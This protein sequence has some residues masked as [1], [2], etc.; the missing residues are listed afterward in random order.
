MHQPQPF[1]L[2]R[3]IWGGPDAVLAFIATVLFTD[4]PEQKLKLKR[5]LWG[6]PLTVLTSVAA[7]LLI[8][9]IAVTLLKPDA[10]FQP[11]TV[12]TPV[13]D[14]VMAVTLAVFVF[15]ATA[16]YSLD[17]VRAYRSLAAKVLLVSF[18]PDIALAIL[19]W[20]GGGW[21]EAIVLMA[22]HAAVWGICVSI[23]PLVTSN[24]T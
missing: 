2:K 19:H 21:P 1:N 18:V 24:G 23:L 8:R 6:W 13:F 7:V 17:A 12:A 14:T 20:F 4:Q 5:L 11:L 3:I 15:V 10:E 16:R 22:M 9:L